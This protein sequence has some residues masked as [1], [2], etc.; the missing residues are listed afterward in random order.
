MIMLKN[1]RLLDPCTRTDDIRD[2]LIS[3]GKIIKTGRELYLDATLMARA[4][5]E[6]L[7]V[8]DCTGLCAAP[9]FVDV[10]VH[11]R[12][13]GF[14]YKEDIASGAMAAAKGGFT[15]IVAMAN[16]KPPIDTPELIFE[17]LKKGRNTPINVLTC[18]CITKGMKGEELA[19][20]NELRE[21]GAIGFTDDGRPLLDGNLAREAMKYARNIKMPLSFHEEDP[22]FIK[23][24][25]INH[26]YSSDKMH[27]FG[28]DRQAEISMVERDCKLARETGATISIQHISAKESVELVRKA[29]KAGARVF[30][31]ATPH[32]FSLTD[33]DVI[34]YGTL[35]KMNPPLREEEDRMAII[36]GLKDGSIDIIATD[37]APHS[38]EEKNKDFVNAPSGIIGL[39]TSFS[40]GFM[41]LVKPGYL[42]LLDLVNKM[43]YQ[44]ARLYNMDRGVLREDEIA[45]IVVFD[46][47]KEW[48]YDKSESKSCNSPWLGETLQGK[49]IY[50]ICKGNVVYE[51]VE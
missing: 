39:E 38:V 5:G 46:I 45:D 11:L 15:T 47:N 40:L 37:H 9:G 21:A 4:N 8:Y 29:K 32:H 1:V 35:A 31:E 26:G 48:K 14:E 24:N 42:S 43:S 6:R 34:K 41:N 23:E 20:L 25:G 50:T 19:E 16:T 49:I 12:E 7:K 36:E 22:Q 33:K 18:A 51:N 3:E 28:S 17:V 30:A 2:I 13:P 10:H 44:P 27:I